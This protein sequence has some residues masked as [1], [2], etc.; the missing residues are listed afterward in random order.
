MHA[1]SLRAKVPAGGRR[2]FHPGRIRPRRQRQTRLF[3][4]RAQRGAQHD[5]LPDGDN[6]GSDRRTGLTALQQLGGRAGQGRGGAPRQTILGDRPERHAG[7][8]A[9]SV[10]CDGAAPL[11]VRV[12]PG[13][14]VQGQ[15]A[16]PIDGG[17]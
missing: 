8:Y 12:R 1:Q 5:F 2:A 16:D 13:G 11:A 9:R 17:E 7:E 14:E 4:Q 10:R 6:V 3:G 15:F